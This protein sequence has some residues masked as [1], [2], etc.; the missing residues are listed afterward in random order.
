[1]WDFDRLLVTDR[2]WLRLGCWNNGRSSFELAHC[3]DELGL[4][5]H[6]DRITISSQCLESYVSYPHI[7]ERQPWGNP[8]VSVSALIRLHF[9]SRSCH[10][11]LTGHKPLF[12]SLQRPSLDITICDA[13]PEYPSQILE[14]ISVGN[15]SLPSSNMSKKVPNRLIAPLEWACELQCF[16]EDGWCLIRLL[17]EQEYQELPARYIIVMRETPLLCCGDYAW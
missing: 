17:V 12:R 15:G 9:C 1:M 6:Q 11:L 7:S 2:S 10:R 5:S 16:S 13:L 3:Q 4:C 8:Q 14:F